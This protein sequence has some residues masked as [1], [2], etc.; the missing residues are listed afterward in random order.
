MIALMRLARLR[1]RGTRAC[2]A[3]PAKAL[4]TTALLAACTGSD[5]A[6]LMQGFKRVVENHVGMLP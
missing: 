2:P 1:P 3:R 6:R 5:G 4:A